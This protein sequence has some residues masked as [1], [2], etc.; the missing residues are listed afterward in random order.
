MD[1]IDLTRL[2][3]DIND[4]L[5]R[6]LGKYALAGGSNV[7]SVYVKNK[8]LLTDVKGLTNQIKSMEERVKQSN[9]VEEDLIKS[10]KEEQ[11]LKKK[12][13][14]EE[15]KSREEAQVRKVVLQRLYSK[16]SE[17]TG[18]ITGRIEAENRIYQS[19]AESNVNFTDSVEN[20]TKY[21]NNLGMSID[22]YTKFLQ[23]NAREYNILQ[24]QVGDVLKATDI[25]WKEISKETGATRNEMQKGL[26]T[27][28]K[29]LISTGEMTQLSATE[30]RDGFNSFMSDIKLLGK[31]VGMNTDSILKQ[32]ESNETHWQLQALMANDKT[33]ESTLAMQQAGF[34]TE[35]IVYA[36]TGRMSETVSSQMAL[37]DVTAMQLSAI[38]NAAAQGQFSTAEDVKNIALSLQENQIYQRA[39]EQDRARKQDATMQYLAVSDQQFFTALDYSASQRAQSFGQFAQVGKG[40]EEVNEIVESQTNR[41]ISKILEENNAF[42]MTQ[43][44]PRIIEIND[45]AAAMNKKMADFYD[46][47]NDYLPYLKDIMQLLGTG[48][49]FLDK[50]LPAVTGIAASISILKDG[51]SFVKS[52][53][54]FIKSAGNVAKPLTNF[55]SKASN[56][57]KP[58][59]NTSTL[60]GLYAAGSVG[61]HGYQAYDAYNRGDTAEALSQGIKGT[62]NAAAVTI[63][64]PKIGGAFAAGM[65]TV[66]PYVERAAGWVGENLV[67]LFGGGKMSDEEKTKMQERILKNRE[68]LN[69]QRSKM[70]Y[71]TP[72]T[73]K[74]QTTTIPVEDVEM[75]TPIPTSSE[76]M[77]TPLPKQS[78][79]DE[80]SLNE[81]STMNGKLSQLIDLFSDVKTNIG[82]MSS[83]MPVNNYN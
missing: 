35:Q 36:Q 51:I 13:L 18:F 7:F 67:D 33:R 58:L 17:F 47:V 22:E 69:Q 78:V 71:N 1:N 30:Y 43:L 49:T 40:S 2:L 77:M 41:E 76:Q 31:A 83:Q 6:N 70:N 26:A 39:L 46:S 66:L 32:I 64:G 72:V 12:E 82:Q 79:E 15:Q 21:A 55:A 59:S 53:P 19:I 54:G 61:Y 24:N 10:M 16:L 80:A 37:N 27:Y 62:I 45:T 57:A 29:M 5:N 34:T 48:G 68:L 4:L 44:G 20:I 50:F 25:N 14:E 75:Q 8:D 60:G 52:I 23:A 42:Q 11:D 73:A 63:A 38:R 3:I 81:L 65:D 9:R 28:T 74:L 56:V